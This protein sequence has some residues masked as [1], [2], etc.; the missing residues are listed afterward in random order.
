MLT[1][2]G[3]TV[4]T[5]AYMSPEQARGRDLDART[6]LFSLGV[7]LYEMATRTRPFHGETA[8]VIFDAIFNRAPT[9]AV[10]LNPDVSPEFERIIARLL[11]KDRD[12]RY[13]T[14]ADV[15]ADLKRAQ[16]EGLPGRTGSSSG[17]G[18]QSSAI[19]QISATLR[20]PRVA[21]PAAIVIVA[22][23]V[24]GMLYSRRAP[25]LTE[26]DAILL[27]DVANT[28][29][30]PLFDG[31]LTQALS[32]KL[33]ESPF[34][35][36]APDDRIQQTLRLMGRPPD[37]RVTSALGREICQRQGLK[38][39]VA[40][41]IASLGTQYVIMLNAINC[42]SGDAIA[43][44]QAEAA[45][46][47]GVLRALGTAT[48]S[49][50]GRLGES[51]ASIQ[52]FDAHLE[53]ATT[54]SLE[55][56]KAY[57]LG[58]ALAGAGKS[59]EAVPSLKRAI[60]LDPNFAYAY[61]ILSVA[62]S[63]LGEPTLREEYTT[64][65]Y[66]HRARVTE[67]ERLEITAR[68]HTLVTG[69]LLKEFETL[70]LLRQTYPREADALNA[71]GL[72]YSQLGQFERA[73]DAYREEVRLRPDTAVFVGNL[74]G[75]Y[76]NLNR[77]DEAKAVLEHAVAQKLESPF[78][79]QWLW[80]IASLQSD[81][82]AADKEIQ[83]LV[84]H[85]PSLAIAV[86]SQMV[87]FEGKLRDM[88]TFATKQADVNARAGLRGAAALGWVNVA[89]IEAECGD[90]DDA[91]KDV[92]TAIKLAPTSRDVARQ[93]AVALAIGG[94][95]KEAQPLLDQTLKDYPPT[96]TLAKAVYIPDIRAALDLAKGSAAAA[97]EE[98][99]AAAPY[100][101]RDGLTMYLRASA[102][103]AANRPADAAAEF[104]KIIDRLR[105]FPFN[106]SYT[107]LAQLGLGRSLAR[108]GDLD[109]SRTAYQDFFAAWKDAD[110]DI[111]ILVAARQEYARLK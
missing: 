99:Q 111:P 68:Y 11:E 51:L 37:E 76:I 94:I 3:S 108:Q 22:A 106:N 41:S 92:A 93:A 5:V 62:Y 38:A 78:I 49:L 23:V 86:Q 82:G 46:K 109:K 48:T 77:L 59:Q 9:Q 83:W 28:T 79:H 18:T 15:R 90:L 101:S 53:E 54:S 16:R 17:V 55:A 105:S 96:D 19:S 71:L 39:M 60:E 64:Q 47:E 67:R 45:N 91:R 85:V 81:R 110:P 74:A 12:I 35:N 30:D 26:R 27:A 75:S 7:V 63:G 52:K 73:A 32:V 2:P 98:L 65:A 89:V 57:T 104:A 50:R 84:Q 58:H 20:R 102:Y 10:R 14:A 6:D 1:S 72:Y 88:R 87:A 25:A 40:G 95:A 8:A 70:T 97:I 103:L 66:E 29:G 36:V 21:V 100:D 31:T 34:L 24:G 56:L 13:Q 43:R 61:Y 42:Q 107:P 44:V 4:G 33:D 69:D 80:R